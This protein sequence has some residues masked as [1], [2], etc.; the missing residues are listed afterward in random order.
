MMKVG[1]LFF[2]SLILNHFALADC[3]PVEWNLPNKG[4]ACEFVADFG[5]PA[6]KQIWSCKKQQS[7]NAL[8]LVSGTTT[9]QTEGDVCFVVNS[10]LRQNY[11]QQ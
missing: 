6:V 8:Y 10:V 9:T 11:V 2:I 5:T 3:Y 4:T 7:P 1:C